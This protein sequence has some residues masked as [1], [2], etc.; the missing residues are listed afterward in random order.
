M[1][2]SGDM[3]LDTSGGDM[4]SPL[5][6]GDDSPVPSPAN[7]DMAQHNDDQ[8]AKRTCVLC[9]MVV[10]NTHVSF[11]NHASKHLHYKPLVLFLALISR[12]F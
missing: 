6:V 7:L 11:D 1:N 10:A 3:S 2:E 8:A 5:P 12:K 9:Q 4:L